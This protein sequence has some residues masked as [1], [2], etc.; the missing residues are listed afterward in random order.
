[1]LKH[2]I[3]SA[4]LILGGCGRALVAPEP[5][6]DELRGAPTAITINEQG[7]AVVL[8]AAVWRDFSP[9]GTDPSYR[10]LIARLALRAGGAALPRGARIEFVW[11]V[12]RDTVWPS[13]VR[14]FDDGQYWVG[15]GPEWPIGSNVD[16]VVRYRD[17][18]RPS[19]L[20]RTAE[21]SVAQVG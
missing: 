17:A 15:D 18:H 7:A 10:G 9:G 8:D 21:R 20:L 3:C 19:R 6:L 13:H 16:V 12:W 1:M 5:T 14:S 11:V 4:T 2:L